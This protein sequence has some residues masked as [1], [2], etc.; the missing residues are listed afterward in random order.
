MTLIFHIDDH[1]RLPW[2]FFK[3]LQSTRHHKQEY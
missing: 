3:G 1:A 2:R